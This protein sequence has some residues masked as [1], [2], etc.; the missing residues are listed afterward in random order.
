MLLL[1]TPLPRLQD[2]ASRQPPGGQ[3]AEEEAEDAEEFWHRAASASGAGVS[4]LQPTPR[5]QVVRGTRVHH[6]T[7]ACAGCTLP[8]EAERKMERYQESNKWG[9]YLLLNHSPA[10]RRPAGRCNGLNTG[11]K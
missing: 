2:G 6:G 8:V 10:F 9:T 1:S 4:P 11:I 5:V 3:E 7:A